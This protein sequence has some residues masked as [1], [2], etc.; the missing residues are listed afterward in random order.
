MPTSEI[1][2]KAPIIVSADLATVGK[3]LRLDLA[4]HIK[5]YDIIACGRNLHQSVM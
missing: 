4:T 3:H 1:G 5:V 2:V